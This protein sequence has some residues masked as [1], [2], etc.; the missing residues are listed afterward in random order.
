[1]QFLAAD[2]FAAE[3]QELACRPKSA[4]PGLDNVQHHRAAANDSTLF[5][6]RSCR[7]SRVQPYQIVLLRSLSEDLEMLSRLFG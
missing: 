3:L 4:K 1:M 5:V 7:A 6:P 2:R